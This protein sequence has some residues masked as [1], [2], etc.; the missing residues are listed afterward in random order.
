ME[1]T[2]IKALVQYGLTGVFAVLA[3]ALMACDIAKLAGSVFD[4]VG[5][6]SYV[7]DASL[8]A[9]L[10]MF[11]FV[12]ALSSLLII[13]SVVGLVGVLINNAKLNMQF[14]NK[15]LAI[16]LTVFALLG[17]ILTIV[18]LEGITIGAG[19]VCP[20]VFGAL[21]AFCTFI[22]SNKKSA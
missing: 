18:A 13:T 16:A 21:A 22:F 2:K 14:I 1:K 4:W 7:E 19:A 20:F 12:I 9:A 8:T 10:V 11:I 5:S 15:I 17:M 3:L 6:I